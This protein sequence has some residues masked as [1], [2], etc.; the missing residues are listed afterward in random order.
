[1]MT[2]LWTLVV[3]FLLLLL[4]GIVR[5]TK[6]TVFEYERGLRFSR[7]HFTGVLSPGMYWHLGV[8]TEIRKVDVRET[9]VAV[10]GQEVLSADGVAIKAS[11]AATCQVADPALAVLKSENFHAA[12]HT[13][14][15]I[16]LRALTSSTPIEELLRTRGEMPAQLKAAAAPRLRGIG[17]ELLDVSLRD[18][19][20]PGELK[21]IF[22]QVVKARQEG[23]G[24]AGEG[25]RRDGGTAEPSKRSGDDRPEPVAH[26][27]ARAAGAR[28]ATGQYAGAGHAAGGDD[29]PA[30]RTAGIRVAG[31]SGK[32]GDRGLTRLRR[33]L[34]ALGILGHRQGWHRCVIHRRSVLLRRLFAWYDWPVFLVD[35]VLTVA[36]D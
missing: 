9:R 10:T 23:T 17:I 18:L 26:A 34:T 24:R 25:A 3:V 15:Q 20:F 8:F 7:G 27:T 12:I 2:M 11:L 33:E 13:E 29:D 6:T 19:T 22:T 30:S 32:A 36:G 1:M 21:K 5:P 4:V 31:G 28:P 14:L 35:S 16:A